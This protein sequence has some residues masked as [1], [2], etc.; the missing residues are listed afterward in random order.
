[1]GDLLP[2][3]NAAKAVAEP[4]DRVVPVFQFRAIVPILGGP[5][6]RPAMVINDHRNKPIG[7]GGGTR[8]L[9]QS[10]S[11]RLSFG[12][13][14]IGS[15]RAYRVGFYPAWFRRYRAD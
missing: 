1:M 8:R 4:P 3:C 5:V 11:L 13:G 2:L 7:P 6:A 14:E 12:G 10:S 9:H 15:T